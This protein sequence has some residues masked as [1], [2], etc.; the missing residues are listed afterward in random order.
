MSEV[1]LKPRNAYVHTPKSRRLFGLQEPPTFYPT[2]EDFKDT[3]Q[4][5]ESIAEEGV[6]YGI[7]K[8]VPPPSWNPKFAVDI[9][10]GCPFWFVSIIVLWLTLF[11]S[12]SNSKPGSRP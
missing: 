8:I 9:G 2:K 4:Y 6:K 1:S 5:I 7:I 10:V 3:Y 11:C 12:N